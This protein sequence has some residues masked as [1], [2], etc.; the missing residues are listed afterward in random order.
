M[1]STMTMMMTTRNKPRPQK[2]TN[3]S[4]RGQR[5]PGFFVG[6]DAR[7]RFPPSPRPCLMV[8]ERWLSPTGEAGE[9][10]NSN[11]VPTLSPTMPHGWGE[12]AEPNGRS[13]RGGSRL[14]KQNRPSPPS[15]ALGTSPRQSAG[16]GWHPSHLLRAC[17]YS[18]QHAI[19]PRSRIKSSRR[20]KSGATSSLKNVSAGAQALEQTQGPKGRRRKVPATASNRPVYCGLLLRGSFTRN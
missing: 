2:P 9:G 6:V 10:L 12:V 20:K 5:G 8:G 16:R 18:V 13:R 19:Q 11:C 14:L 4:H 7:W 15:E 3:S 1:T 17:T